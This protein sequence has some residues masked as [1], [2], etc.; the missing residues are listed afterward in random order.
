METSNEIEKDGSMTAPAFRL[1]MR[2][3][4]TPGRVY[5][6]NK[7]EVWIG[8]N[9]SNDITINDGEVSRRHAV[10]RY[11]AGNYVIEDLNS[12]NGSFVN[13]FRLMGPHSLVSGEKISL[14][15]NIELVFDALRPDLAATVV[16]PVGD[17]QAPSATVYPP[18]SPQLVPIQPMQEI[19]PQPLPI[20]PKQEIPPQPVPV[21]PVQVIPPQPEF[22]QPVEVIPLLPDEPDWDD[23]LSI[24]EEE[25]RE[26]VIGRSSR[27]LWM[28]AGCGCLVL[29][30]VA[31]AATALAIEYYNLWCTLFG[32]WIPGC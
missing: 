31:C 23:Q 32:S 2:R 14:G 29:V 18:P 25:E 12:T 15:E 20:Q 26:L 9:L 3:G 24:V 8:R 16:R 5:D 22:I 10:L 30:A 6:L 7:S 21:Q 1:I 17:L 13:G 4:P 27:E 19:P 11:D 28:I